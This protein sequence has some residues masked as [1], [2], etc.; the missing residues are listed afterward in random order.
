MRERAITSI[1]I[2]LALLSTL[3]AA[4]LHCSSNT[5]NS[6]AQPPP[7]PPPLSTQQAIDLRV[8]VLSSLDCDDPLIFCIDARGN[9]QFDAYPTDI[10]PNDKLVIQVVDDPASLD[11]E[12][13]TISADGQADPAK[14]VVAKAPSVTAGG[15][16]ASD[17]DAASDAA[18]T[19]TVNTASSNAVVTNPAKWT[20]IMVTTITPP[21]GATTMRVKF[22][23][24]KTST[25]AVIAEQEILFKVSLGK[26]YV[27]T[28]LLLPF[29]FRG[30]REVELADVPGTGAHTVESREG[31]RVPL[32]LSLN[33]FPLGLR[34]TRHQSYDAVTKKWRS[35]NL[36]YYGLRSVFLQIGTTLS[37]TELPFR[38]WFLGVGYRL[39]IGASVSMG[40]GLVRGQFPTENVGYGYLLPAGSNVTY[41]QEKYMARFY[42][43]VTVP[44][45]VLRGILATFTQ[46]NALSSS[47][48][49][50]KGAT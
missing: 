35:E 28:G 7:S 23:R 32:A 38:D 4:L 22:R 50:P 40:V 26:R 1:P 27:E 41:S 12:T 25:Q 44:I 33:I 2:G 43:G 29:V 8:Q 39:G 11:D 30:K 24:L 37:F 18:P 10:G 45:E 9:G 5:T 36:F 6:Q 34:D 13:L 16:A 47:S 19:P 46:I 49:A 31:L 15:D 14:I 17:S 3:G 21:L 48:S 42:F 20:R